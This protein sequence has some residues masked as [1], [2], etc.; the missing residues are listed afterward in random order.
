MRSAVGFYHA[1]IGRHQGC[2]LGLHG[3]TPRAYRGGVQGK[4][5]GQHGM[6]GHGVGKQGFE[7]G[8][9]FYVLDT[10]FNDAL[11]DKTA[12]TD[13][14]DDVKMETGPFHRSHQ[15]GVRRFKLSPGQFDPG[16]AGP[17]LTPRTRPDWALRP[18][19][20]AFDKPDDGAGGGVPQPRHGRRG[21]DTSCGLNMDRRPHRAVSRRQNWSWFFDR[22]FA[23]PSCSIGFMSGGGFQ[24]RVLGITGL[25]RGQQAMR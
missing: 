23:A 13:V 5:V 24:V 2:R 12:A 9:T 7:L 21:S 3:C 25:C 6:P 17:R 20:R 14:K 8:R 11:S 4:L 10:P 19:V 22:L 16:N 15:L 1:G 18:A